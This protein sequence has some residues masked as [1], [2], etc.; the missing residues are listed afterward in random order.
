MPD[1][2]RVVP[3]WQTGHPMTSI[4]MIRQ[5]EIRGNQIVRRFQTIQ[6]MRPG[7][8]SGASHPRAQ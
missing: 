7:L 8:G 1:L 3:S 2:P 4:Y 6:T 5:G